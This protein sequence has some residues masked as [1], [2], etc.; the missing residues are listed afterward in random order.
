MAS[1]SCFCC[2]KVL[3][4]IDNSAPACW[5]RATIK[6]IRGEGMTMVRTCHC[7]RACACVSQPLLCIRKCAA[8]VP[9]TPHFSLLRF[10][11]LLWYSCFSWHTMALMTAS[12]N[13]LSPLVFALPTMSE[14]PRAHTHAY[15]RTLTR[16]HAQP[17]DRSLCMYWVRPPHFC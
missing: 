3:Y 12:T 17:H 2:A 9:Q 15:T 13:G 7:V 11:C 6:E 1:A 5:A 4:F 16:I 8:F 10:C 14:L